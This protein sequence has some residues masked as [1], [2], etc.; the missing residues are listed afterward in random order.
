MSVPRTI[1]ISFE[2]FQLPIPFCI[3]RIGIRARLRNG[4][5]QLDKPWNKFLEF[6]FSVF[7]FLRWVCQQDGGAIRKA[8]TSQSFMSAVIP[9][10]HD[11]RGGQKSADSFATSRIIFAVS[12]SRCFVAAEDRELVTCADDHNSY[13]SP[14]CPLSHRSVVGVVCLKRWAC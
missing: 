9:P 14:V 10:K 7:A 6:F 13:M 12:M 3:F 1:R 5:L 2:Q 11:F 8:R 4:F